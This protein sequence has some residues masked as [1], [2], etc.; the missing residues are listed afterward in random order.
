MFD[1]FLGDGG[2]LFIA[3]VAVVIGFVAAIGFMD[4]QKTKKEQ[5]GRS[6]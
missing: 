4:N 1:Q 5:E 2:N 6:E 3:I